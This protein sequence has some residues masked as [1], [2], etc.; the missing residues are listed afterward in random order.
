MGLAGSSV[1]V[2]LTMQQSRFQPEVE[3][4]PKV[5]HGRDLLPSS[6]GDCRIEFFRG[7]WVKFPD[8]S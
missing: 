2:S 1:L 3:Y 5:G 8:L 6:H 4:H 7:I